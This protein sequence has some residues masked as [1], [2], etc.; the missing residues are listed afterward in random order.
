MICCRVLCPAPH[1]IMLFSG[2]VC[3]IP[4]ICPFWYATIFFGLKKYAKK[5]REF[6]TKIALRQN[7]VNFWLAYLVF[8]LAYLVFWLSYLIF[9]WRAWFFLGVISVLFIILHLLVCLLCILVG[10]LGFLVGVL[11]F[12]FGVYGILCVIFSE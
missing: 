1:C 3:V 6:A 10:V 12:L 11:S 5:V 4:D 8:W 9:C 2:Y 7:S